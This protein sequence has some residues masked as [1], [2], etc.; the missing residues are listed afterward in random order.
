MLIAHLDRLSSLY[1]LSF[2]HRPNGMEGDIND[3]INYPHG[4]SARVARFFLVQHA[5]MEK[6]HTK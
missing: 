1:F 4:M 3:R 5:E 6:K 2:F